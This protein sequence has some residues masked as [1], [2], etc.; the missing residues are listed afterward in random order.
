MEDQQAPKPD[1]VPTS[2]QSN[3]ASPSPE[4]PTTWQFVSEDD[5]T[6]DSDTLTPDDSHV[7]SAKSVVSVSWNAPEFIAHKK[8]AVWY[9][10]LGISTVAL[11]AI[12]F[13]ITRDK[14][15]M[16]VIVFAALLLGGY[17][18]RQPRVLRYSLDDAGLHVGEK[19][20]SYDM[21]KSFSIDTRNALSSIVLMPLKR[22]MPELSLYYSDEDEIKIK[23]ALA[24]RLPL[25]ELRNDLVDNFFRKIRY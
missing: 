21:F 2:D 19:F 3:Q 8:S 6:S 5:K 20:Y 7:L 13:L 1:H 4:P 23:A 17:S 25:E 15:S 18:I 11:A 16:V 22:F 14:V 24:D 9:I 12:V 10:L